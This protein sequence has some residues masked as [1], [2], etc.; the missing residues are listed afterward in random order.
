[1]LPVPDF[2]DPFRVTDQVV[3]DGKPLWLKVTA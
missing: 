2:M 1:M 3:P